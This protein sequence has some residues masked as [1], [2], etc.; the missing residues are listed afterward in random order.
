LSRV[1]VG[2]EA[3]LMVGFPARLLVAQVVFVPVLAWLLRVVRIIPLRLVLA[4]LGLRMPLGR[5]VAILFFLPLHPLAAV[6]AGAQEFLEAQAV[7]VVEPAV[8]E[9]EGLETLQ[10]LRQAKEAM[11]EMD[12]TAHLIM[13][14]AV[15]AARVPLGLPGLLPLGGMVALVLRRLFPVRQLRMLAA[16][17]AAHSTGE[18]QEQE[19]REA[20]VPGQQHLR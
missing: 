19:A 2:V 15:A 17:A 12:L 4:V 9:P 16:V 3:V 6:T 18:R 1:V 10:A 14:A 13:V 8:R 11:A 20:V 7:L 5:R